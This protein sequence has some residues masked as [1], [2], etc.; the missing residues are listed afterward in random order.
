MAPKS[1]LLILHICELHIFWDPK[2]DKEGSC[3]T[4]KL[5]PDEFCAGSPWT[6]KTCQKVDFYCIQHSRWSHLKG[7]VRQVTLLISNYFCHPTN[8][9]KYVWILCGIVN[10]NFWDTIGH[11]YAIRCPRNH[12][13]LNI[14]SRQ[15]NVLSRTAP[16]RWKV[17]SELRSS[18]ARST[19]L[20]L[21]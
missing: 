13:Q 11:T 10:C 20:A 12:L 5:N 17:K 16:M 1:R 19:G 14:L 8:R 4:D 2:I 21:Y 7:R 3:N 18:H 9:I 15:F 6:T